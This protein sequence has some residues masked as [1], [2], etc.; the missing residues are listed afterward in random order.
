MMIIISIV[1]ILYT[2]ALLIHILLIDKHFVNCIDSEMNS[3]IKIKC[4]QKLIKTS[5]VK[6]N[7][8][9]YNINKY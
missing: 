3:S 6:I 2:K 8:H 7:T 5:R 4:L 9:D 1:A